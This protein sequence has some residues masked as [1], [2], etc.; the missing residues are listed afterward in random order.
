MQPGSIMSLHERLHHLRIDS[1][2]PPCGPIADHTHG[3]IL[4]V[5]SASNDLGQLLQ[6]LRLSELLRLNLMFPDP[7][8]LSEDMRSP[9]RVYLLET[10]HEISH[11][12]LGRFC[13][14]RLRES[15][16][17]E[18]GSYQTVPGNNE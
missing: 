13:T 16:Q 5:N 6:E 7:F 17:R 8:H 10:L 18:N 15:S 2:N 3:V 14:R 11:L 12:M 4:L 1:S 9:C